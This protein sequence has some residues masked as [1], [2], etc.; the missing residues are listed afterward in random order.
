MEDYVKSVLI[1]WIG[2]NDLNAV[3]DDPQKRQS[4]G[5]I[6]ATLEKRDYS[7]VVLLYNYD[8]KKVQPY[9]DW[10]LPQTSASVD[11]KY[12]KLKSPI[13]FR[14]IHLAADA[15]LKEV[16]EKFPNCL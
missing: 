13:D 11:A 10:L 14:D 16:F 12:V 7:D 2:Q 9:L 6:L 1:S 4:H 8:K 15:Q 5:P 3:S